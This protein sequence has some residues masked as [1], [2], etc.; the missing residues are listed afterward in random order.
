VRSKLLERLGLVSS[1]PGDS[2]Y[3]AFI[4]YSHAVDGIL[5]PA[6]QR[7]L[8]RFA[9]PWYRLEAVRVFRDEASLSANP[10]LW[11]SIEQALDQSLFFVLLASPA[12]AGSAWVRREAAQWRATKPVEHLLIALTEGELAWDEGS[13]DFDWLRTTALPA[14]LSGAFSE[15][16]RFIDLRWAH[17]GEQLSLSH[18]R[19]RDAV[20]ELAAPLH[21]VPK[22]VIAGEEVRQHRR[23]VRIARAAALSLAVLTVASVIFGVFA[24]LQ[25]NEARRQR[26]LAT[27]R[28]LVQAASANL[29]REIDLAALLSLE[30][31]RIRPSTETKS[32]LIRAVER[33]DHI[34]ALGHVGEPVARIAFDAAGTKLAAVGTTSVSLWAL[35]ARSRIIGTLDVPG[36]RSVA[37]SPN[38]KTVAVGGPRAITIWTV[39]AGAHVIRRLPL[40]AAQ[41]LTF[42]ANG[43]RLEA[44]GPAEASEFDVP[45]G[46]RTRRQPLGM[47]VATA[48]FA[49]GVPHA[50]VGGPHILLLIDLTG[51]RRARRIPTRETLS[52]ITFDRAGTQVAGLS[53][54]GNSV[55]VWNATTG[56]VLRSLRLAEEALTVEFKR[57]GGLAI[58]TNDGTLILRSLHATGPPLQLRGPAEKIFDI[59]RRGD[60]ELVTA[61]E[62]GDLVLWDPG[63]SAVR[64]E[65]PRLPDPIADADYASAARKLAVGGLGDVTTIWSFEGG[66]ARSTTV[67]SGPA[68]A[69]AVDRSGTRV[70]VAERGVS[71]YG[72]SRKRRRLEPGGTDDVSLVKSAGDIVAWGLP[73]EIALWDV[74][75]SRNLD[76][77]PVRGSLRGLDLSDDGNL[78]VAA[79]KGRVVLWDLRNR[80]R[81]DLMRRAVASAV[82]ITRTGKLTAVATNDR[83]AVVDTGGRVRFTV[84]IPQGVSVRLAWSPD[85]ETL[86]IGTSEPRLLLVGV[87]DGRVLGGPLH[88]SGGP[89]SGLDFSSDGRTLATATQGGLVTLWDDMVWSDVASMQ[90]R[91]CAVAG[92]SLS[93]REWHEFIPGKPYHATCG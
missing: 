9:K 54:R 66:R 40:A 44:V 82:A 15:E 26:D 88:V 1:P 21:G 49:H 37:F 6:L 58:G 27:S 31:Y 73:H 93:P 5:A 80:Q 92:R 78:V 61:G 48:A 38:G 30:A 29:D 42:S 16:P 23:T 90:R 10:G 65:L 3:H 87:R 62:Q 91:L 67:S 36:V 68:N 55:T 72:P 76:A 83:V 4:S 60:T 22:D 43:R 89:I 70:A 56:K 75:H 20:A 86:A 2:S 50:A 7:G 14:T 59:E 71:L 84:P 32:S 74:A 69:V 85:E 79:E 39:E 63:R 8:R 19:F 25:R 17:S 64:R 41:A 28:A 77:L 11:S 51:H 57:D 45:T 13:N 33:S 12:A 81:T 47:P 46:S 18:A 53:L 35:R 24:L 34:I 52:S